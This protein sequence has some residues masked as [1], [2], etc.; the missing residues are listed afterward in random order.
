MNKTIH[1]EKI[2]NLDLL[3]YHYLTLIRETKKELEM[4][5]EKLSNIESLE[6]ELVQQ[7]DSTASVHTAKEQEYCE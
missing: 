3:R 5:R 7:T 1:P 4:L 2:D 6:S